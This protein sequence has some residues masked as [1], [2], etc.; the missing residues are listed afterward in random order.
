MAEK[1][2]TLVLGASD[3][4]S[5][6]SFLAVNKLIA[7]GHPVEAIGRR[8][9]TVAGVAIGTEKKPLEAVDTVTLY[10]SPTHQKEYYDYIL[11]LKP[12][13]IIFNPG[14]EN[15]ELADLARENQ[16]YPQEACTLVLL[17]TGQY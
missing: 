10:L 13:R 12:K 15:E 16:I 3:N 11:Q 4:P 9:A 6:Y 2:K 8:P 5:R 7:N 14:A 17:S 1:K